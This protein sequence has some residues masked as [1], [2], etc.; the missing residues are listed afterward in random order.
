MLMSRALLVALF[1]IAM[2]GRA[3][4]NPIDWIGAAVNGIVTIIDA[5]TDEGETND[6]KNTE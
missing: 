4:A 5:A 3:V 1:M 2:A 6:D